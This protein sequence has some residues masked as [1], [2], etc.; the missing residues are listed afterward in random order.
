MPLSYYRELLNF[1]LRALSDRDAAVDTVQETYARV[2][3]A[4]RSGEAIADP[5]AFLY[6]TARNVMTDDFRRAD[7]RQHASLDDLTVED[8]PV[9]AVNRQPEERCASSQYATAIVTVI[10]GLPPRCREAFVM[11]KFDGMSYVQIAEAMGISVRT[12]E[13]H[14]KLAMD[15]CWQ[16]ADE[17]V[18]KGSTDGSGPGARSSAMGGPVARRR[19]GARG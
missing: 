15:A 4:G 6:R 17:M 5:R 1:C 13:M 2:L 16:C 18:G 9:S 3:S 19:A 7:V 10:E 12:V 8:E 14:L 11:F